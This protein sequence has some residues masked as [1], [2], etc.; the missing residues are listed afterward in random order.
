MDTTTAIPMCPTTTST[1][2]IVEKEVAGTGAARK[3]KD[4]QGLG[5]GHVSRPWYVFFYYYYST[6]QI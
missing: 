5:T 4:Q 2:N 3:Q 6:I 1:R